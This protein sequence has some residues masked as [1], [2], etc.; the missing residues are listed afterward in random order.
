MLQIDSSL[1]PVAC[2][3]QDKGETLGISFAELANISKTPE[4]T[5]SL[6]DLMNR[7]AISAFWIDFA[8]LQDW[9]KESGVL[10]MLEPFAKF[11]GYGEIFDAVKDVITAKLSV[12]SF[13]ICCESLETF[14]TEFN[15]VEVDA[16]DGLMSKV[17]KIARK[18]L[19]VD[20]KE[21]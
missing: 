17:I 13:S 1:S 18:Y 2:L 8:G 15:I 21:D 4:L 5:S 3:I 10:F 11:M 20:K 16:K 9:I 19:T 12:P 14:R 7:E 6:Q